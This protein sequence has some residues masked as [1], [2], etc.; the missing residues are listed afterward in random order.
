MYLSQL[1]V[2]STKKMRVPVTTGYADKTCKNIDY[3]PQG[4][5]EGKL[6][7]L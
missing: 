4:R 1:H 6:L 7:F 3:V 2:G 5:L